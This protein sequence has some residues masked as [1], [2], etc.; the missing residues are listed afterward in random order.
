MIGT[1]AAN[2]FN[3]VNFDGPN[4]GTAAGQGTNINGVSNNG[5][6]VG[7]TINANG[8]FT[9]F[10]ASANPKMSKVLTALSG[11]PEANAFGVN[12]ACIVVGTDGNGNA[13]FLSNGV[14]HTFIPPGGTS[15]VA[16]GINDHDQIVGQY[17]TASGSMPGFVRVNAK[18]Y[19]TIN[20]PA[21]TTTDI[22]NAQSINNNGEIAGFYVGN[23]GQDHGFVAN[24]KS[25]VNGVITAVPVAD[26]V[27]PTVAGEPARP[28][29]SRRSSAS[30]IKGSP[31][32]TMVIPPPVNMASSTTRTPASIPSSTTRARRST[33]A[34]K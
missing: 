20:A 1:V 4:G 22:V 17:T 29:S 16:F 7:F 13:F 10:T 14:V 25:A 2:G 9:N 28:S 30:I 15:A 34:W 6:A 33:K 19:L 32:V 31:S 26:P 12:S 24:I 5:I 3:F 11:L 18:T 23:D 21:G 27:I 8:T